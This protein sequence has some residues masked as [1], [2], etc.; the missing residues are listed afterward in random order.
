MSLSS[1][2]TALAV[3]A[4]FILGNNSDPT[5]ALINVDFPLLIVDTTNVGYTLFILKFNFSN[6]FL[7]LSVSIL[8]QLPY[9]PN[10][11]STHQFFFQ[12]SLCLINLSA[13][14]A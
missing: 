14:C 9:L 5:M 6:K 4:R 3:H 12:I 11:L 8:F 2:A 10:F 7:A 13:S 1:I